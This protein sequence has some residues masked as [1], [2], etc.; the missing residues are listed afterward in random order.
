VKIACVL[1]LCRLLQSFQF[2]PKAPARTF[3]VL[4]SAGMSCSILARGAGVFHTSRP[5]PRLNFLCS[6]PTH[7]MNPKRPCHRH[8]RHK[9]VRDLNRG[10]FSP[11]SKRKGKAMGTSN[12]HHFEKV[13]C[14]PNCISPLSSPP[15]QPRQIPCTDAAIPVAGKR[16]A[17][18]GAPSPDHRIDT[19]VWPLKTGTHL[20][21]S[22]SYS[23]TPPLDA[24]NAR[25]WHVLESHVDRL[26]RRAHLGRDAW[27]RVVPVRV[28]RICCPVSCLARVG[29]RAAG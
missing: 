26:S 27:A 20:P 15:P 28:L 19:A 1:V 5:H 29:A 11:L 14:P 6:F 10:A 21:V 9:K 3:A 24:D 8:G 12:K 22:M 2:M 7:D 25:F 4:R 13:M 18:I 23:L 16:V 17:L